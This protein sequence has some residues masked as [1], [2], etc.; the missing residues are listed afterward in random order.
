MKNTVLRHNSGGELF[1][2]MIYET[3]GL[4]PVIDKLE[5]GLY[6]KIGENDI[7]FCLDDEDLDEVIT[8][9]TN[10]KKFIKEWNAK[11]VPIE[12]DTQDK[13]C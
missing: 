13:P 6:V 1:E 3:N 9:L 11:Q 5:V 12:D 7:D 8:Y 4:N 10:A 2:L